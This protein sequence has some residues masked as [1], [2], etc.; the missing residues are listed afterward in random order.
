MALNWVICK[1]ALPIPGAKNARQL[2]ELAGAVGWRLS[3]GEVAELDRVSSR[4]PAGLGFPVV[5]GDT[6]GTLL[7][8]LVVGV[9]GTRYAAVH[10]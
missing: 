7:W 1:G 5:S 8:G 9:R 2:E 3:E 4:V 6:R 10:V